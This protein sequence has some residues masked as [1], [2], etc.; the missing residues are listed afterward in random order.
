MAKKRTNLVVYKL[1]VDGIVEYVGCG[2][3]RR[4]KSWHNPSRWKALGLSV[5]PEVEII[6]TGLEEQDALE[7]EA[8][9]ITRL[10]P[11]KNKALWGSTG[12]LRPWNY[13]LTKA[14]SDK[15]RGGR[16]LGIPFTDEQKA[17]M[18]RALVG[19]ATRWMMGRSPWNKGLTKEDPRV[20]QCNTSYDLEKRRRAAAITWEK[21]RAKRKSETP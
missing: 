8:D 3:T 18:S 13:G 2:N 17:T 5:C 1:V 11:R 9:L 14:D 7:M 4:P 16:P 15:I 20:R 21:R 6:A 19:K 12:G 10:K